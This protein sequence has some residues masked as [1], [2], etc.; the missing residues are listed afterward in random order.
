MISDK[1]CK[2]RKKQTDKIFLAMA[3]HGLSLDANGPHLRRFTEG[4]YVFMFLLGALVLAQ[5]INR[6]LA[7]LWMGRGRRAG[8]LEQPNAGRM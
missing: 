5:S 4:T 8:K 7:N 3:P 6:W 2:I 1:Y